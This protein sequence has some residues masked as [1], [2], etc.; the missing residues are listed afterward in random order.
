M[1]LPDKER[2]RL[3]AALIERSGSIAAK[4]CPECRQSNWA[5]IDD[6][7]LA[8]I[9]ELREAD[10]S[11]RVHGD[12]GRAFLLVECRNCGFTKF[13]DVLQLGHNLRVP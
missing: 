6:L 9:V 8:P 5:M 11:Y 1:G 2:N 12:R 7:H 10:H 4:T 13:Y 3:M